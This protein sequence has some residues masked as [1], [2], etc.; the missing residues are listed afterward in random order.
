MG[1]R[2]LLLATT[3]AGKLAEI[4]DALAGVPIGLLSLSGLPPV[5]EPEETG[6]TFAEN[7]RLKAI[8]YGG[9]YGLPTLAEDSGLVIDALGG[10]P[11]VRSA[12]F[13]A[14]DASYPERFQ[15]I[16]RRLARHPDAPRTARFVC[17][18]AIVSGGRVV[19]ETAGVVE[20]VIA[21]FPAGSNGFGYDPIFFYPPYEATFGEVSGE[22]KLRVS[23]RGQAFHQVAAWLRD[24]I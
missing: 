20:G 17:A 2:Q 15:E 21:R 1:W 5:A 11:G 7:A 8:H 13:L 12:R 6:T 22:A 19:F 24:S 4:R 14:A 23:H 16:E 10:E 9:C 18:A 3:N